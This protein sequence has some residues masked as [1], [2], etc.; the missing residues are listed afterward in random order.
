MSNTASRS[1]CA[2]WH[3][4]GIAFV[5]LALA[6]FGGLSSCATIKQNVDAR[7]NLALCTYS[8][9]RIELADLTLENKLLDTV[10]FDVFL[11]IENTS[12]SDVALDRVEGSIQLD[13][14]DML[15]LAHR[16]F[17]RVNKTLTVVEPIRVTL[18]LG[19]I[20]RQLG[21]KP[22]T[23]RALATVWINLLVGDLTLESD[24][25]VTLSYTMPIPYEAIQKMV[26]QKLKEAANMAVKEAAKAA[27]KKAAEAVAQPLEQAG[28]LIKG[29]L[30]F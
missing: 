14:A 11:K 7:A 16:K 22:E 19:N 4:Q 5:L 25:S 29:G 3:A 30:G 28:S 17:V 6:L 8:F 1:L 2:G 24:F 12:P 21:R 26:D 13:S 10:S 15:K 20:I 23:I 27:E 18:P 9:E